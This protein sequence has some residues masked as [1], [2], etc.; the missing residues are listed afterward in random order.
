MLGIFGGIFGRSRE[1]QQLDRALRAVG[2]HPVLVS[3]AVKITT[4][5]LLKEAHGAAPAPDAYGAAAGL[6][7]YCILGAAGFAEANDASRMRAAEARLD[8]ALAAGD[9]LDARL[10][11]LTLHAGAIEA[12]VVDRYGL[13]AG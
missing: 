11:L 9:S 12:G 7:G 5:K 8:A 3:D 4:V 2:L 10:V 13:E 1:Q 6:L